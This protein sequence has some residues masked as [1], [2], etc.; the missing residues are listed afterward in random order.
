MEPPSPCDVQD[1]FFLL[2]TTELNKL[3]VQAGNFMLCIVIRPKK[4]KVL[5][6]PLNK[7]VDDCNTLVNTDQFQLYHNLVIKKWVLGEYN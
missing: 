7:S 5:R 2:T 1:S 6:E 3:K 4:F